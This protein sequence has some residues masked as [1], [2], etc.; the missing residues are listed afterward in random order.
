MLTLEAL[1]LADPLFSTCSRQA[2]ERIDSSFSILSMRSKDPLARISSTS[3]MDSAKDTGPVE[4]GEFVDL[5]VLLPPGEP[6]G[7]GDREESGEAGLVS[8][9][10]PD[11][12]L[13]KLGYSPGS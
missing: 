9:V 13:S 7:L 11:P 4:G 8:L 1:D 10:G 2:A 3:C 5:G 12:K 6:R